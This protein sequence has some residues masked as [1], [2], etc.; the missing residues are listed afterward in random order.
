MSAKKLDYRLSEAELL[1]LKSI[2]NLYK[3]KIEKVAI[4]GSRANGNYQEYSD[5]DLVVYGQIDQSE[6]K[7]LNTLF[8]ESKIGLSIDAKAYELIRYPALKRHIDEES[9][10]LFTNHSLQ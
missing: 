7:R 9:K 4:F 8:D 2:L 6:I 5:I 3:Q 1:S 10:T